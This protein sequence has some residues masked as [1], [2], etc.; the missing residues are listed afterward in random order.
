MISQVVVIVG[1]YKRDQV[2]DGLEGVQVVAFTQE[3]LPLVAG[4]A[5]TWSPQRVAIT[6]RQAQADGHDVSNH[7]AQNSDDAS[8]RIHGQPASGRLLGPNIRDYRSARGQ[9]SLG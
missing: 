4:I 2:R 9:A 8:G 6:N 7:A 1:A 3:R 5:P